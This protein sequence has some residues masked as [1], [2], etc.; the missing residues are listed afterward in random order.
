MRP[1]KTSLAILP[2]HNWAD[3]AGLLAWRAGGALIILLLL[4]SGSTRASSATAM[5][6]CNGNMGSA[7]GLTASQIAGLRASGFTTMVLFT[8]SVQ[9]NGDFT[10]SD[11]STVCSGGVYLGPTNWASLLSQCR[12]APTGV[13]RIEMCIA[14]WGDTSFA[15]IKNRI[16][17][18]GTGSGTVLYKNLQALKGALGID[19]IDYDDETV[20]DA[21]SA[22]SFGQ[23]CVAAGLK[24]TLCPYTNP[25]Y[26]QAVKT[27]LGTNCDQIYLQCYDGGAGNNPATWNTYFG[28]LKVVS[29]YWDWERDTTFLTM[30]QAGQNDGCTGGFLWPSCTGCN[31][32][33]D[34]NEMSQYAAWILDA[35]TPV[36]T[37]VTA[38][39]VVGG[40]VT[41]AVAFGGNNSYQ[42]QVI[43][44]GATNNISGATNATLTLSNLQLTNAAA[45]QL[46]VTNAAGVYVSSA[47][48]L[49]VGSAPMA[50]NNV[51]TASAAQTGLGF[52]IPFTPTWTLAPGSIISGQV[53]TGTNGNFNQ[54]TFGGGRTPNSLTAGGTLT[55][56][57]PGGVTG[58]NYVTCGNDGVSGSSLI[59]TLTNAS[60][61]GYNLTNIT[62]YGGWKD[63][64]R[65]QQAYTVYYSKVAAPSLFINLGSVS[66]NPTDTANT[67][68]A[69]RVTLSPANGVF[70]TNVAAVKFDFTSPASENG[71]CGYAEITM[72]GIPV[73]PQVATNPLPVTA[74]DVVGSQAT[75]MAAFTA[76]KT[77]AYQWQKITAT[78]TNNISGATNTTL[79]LTNLQLTD[80]ASYRLQATNTYGVAVSSASTLTV[81]SVPAAVNNVITA[82]AAQ[83]G[84][85]SGTFTPTWTVVTNGSLIAGQAPSTATG[86]FSEEVPGRNVNLLTAGSLGLTQIAGLYGHTTSTNY[87]TC[88]NGTGPD[89]SSAGSTLVYTLTG[90]ASGYNLTNITVYGGWS[91]AGRDQQAYTVYYSKTN[92]PTTFILLGSVNY[93]PVNPA[94]AQSAT[95]A[96]LTPAAGALGTNV[97]AVKFD[98]TTPASENGFC[99]YA[100]ISL[101]GVPT[102]VVAGNPTNITYQVAAGKLA[103]SWPGDHLGWRLQAQTNNLAH[104]LGT[105]WS[106][107]AGSAITNQLAIPINPANGSVFYRLIYP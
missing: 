53:P 10:F 40:Q 80:T 38:A 33:A 39:D 89:S 8:M 102:V 37:P 73:S 25:S 41:F 30:M 75:F 48:S 65:D 95:R 46:L 99:G 63:A 93:N 86:N 28:G 77:P 68:S 84:T 92:A 57:Q 82:L 23:M 104:G 36:V 44:S 6:F 43:R 12:V 49:T 52:G 18:D 19:A 17:A 91:D 60:A 50:V 34:G 14:Q 3:A 85:G 67:P 51:L 78:L 76:A 13:K 74:A 11:G 69:T 2:V 35:F 4:A 81:S 70:A 54:E 45:Y 105:N 26:W 106:D 58:T 72:Q 9:T 94:G 98:F 1:A 103:L 24:V 29:G 83:T 59:Y 27:G 100:A 55:I 20:Y 107:V 87:C 90:S 31:P 101:G 32:P 79:T 62:V 64:G 16:A 42:W 96:T 88:G 97:A 21:G 22:I 71:Y 15:N 56:S 47:G 61:G 66:F 7:S 5:I